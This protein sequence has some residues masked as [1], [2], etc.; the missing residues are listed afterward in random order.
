M[1]AEMMWR[2]WR[3]RSALG[4]GSF[5]R[6]LGAL[7]VLGS[8]GGGGAQAVML[9]YFTGP[10]GWGFDNSMGLDVDQVVDPGDVF[11]VSIGPP[12]SGVED[13]EL[14]IYLGSELKA[15]EDPYENIDRIVELTFQS[16]VAWEG[17]GDVLF[18]FTDL[19]PSPDG[20]Y[21]DAAIEIDLDSPDPFQIASYGQY[22]FAGFVISEEELQIGTSRTFRYTMNQPQGWEELPGVGVAA[23]TQFIPE[24]ST[25]VLIGFGLLGLSVR[26]RCSHA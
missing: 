9:P 22:F 14:K 23:T 13:G 21:Q 3:L 15:H 16:A 24:P 12:G 5:L 1:A 6:T 19:V 17:Y 2:M 10:G 4:L 11:T 8:M 20:A 7:V 18:V 26:R 25:A